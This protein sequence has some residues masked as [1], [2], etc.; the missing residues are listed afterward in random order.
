MGKKLIIS[1]YS[2]LWSGPAYIRLMCLT[3][4]F[5]VN[6]A[7]NTHEGYASRIR[8]AVLSLV[9]HRLAS[10]NLEDPDSSE[11]RRIKIYFLEN[12]NIFRGE[13]DRNFIS[14]MPQIDLVQLRIID[15]EVF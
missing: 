8:K 1:N 3:I 7:N 13:D 10:I 15:D 9:R 11:H 4:S 12:R 14:T 5:V 2:D 6:T